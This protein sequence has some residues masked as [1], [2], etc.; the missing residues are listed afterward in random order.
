MDVLTK[1]WNAGH[2][3]QLQEAY[4]HPDD[5]IKA[6]RT[7]LQMYTR[8]E[9]P[10]AR[11]TSRGWRFYWKNLAHHPD[12]DVLAVCPSAASFLLC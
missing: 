9:H 5:A 2:A 1:H 6:L 8:Q 12:A 3:S 4:G 7:Q 10:F 11:D